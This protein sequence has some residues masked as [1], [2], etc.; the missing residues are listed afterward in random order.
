MTIGNLSITHTF[1]YIVL[2]IKLGL[3]S[4]EDLAMALIDT[5]GNRGSIMCEV[6]NLC[7][8]MI[9]TSEP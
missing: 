4:C 2:R 5:K 6:L 8:G 1:D 9:P 3:T 7:P